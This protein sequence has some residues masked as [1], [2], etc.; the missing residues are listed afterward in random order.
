LHNLLSR[1]AEAVF[2]MARQVERANNVARILEITANFS[3]DEINTQPWQGVIDLYNDSDFFSEEYDEASPEN[4][5][6]FYIL[7]KKNPNSILNNIAYARENARALRPLLSTEIWTQLN[8]FHAKLQDVNKPQIRDEKVSD[9]CAMVK[10]S[11]QTH[12]GLVS[13]TMFRDEEWYFYTIGNALERA[14]QTTRLVDVKYHLLLPSKHGVG[15]QIDLSQWNAVL[16]SAA[17]FQAFRRVHHRGLS[18]EKVS[19]FLLFD[20]R[21]PRSLTNTTAKAYAQLKSLISL[22]AL[23]G[24]NEVLTLAKELSEQTDEGDIQGIIASGMHEWIDDVQSDIG[25]ITDALA[26]AFF[27]EG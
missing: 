13:E 7:D 5:L 22:Y 6:Q 10:Q 9:F 23:P 4:V 18:G 19:G 20:K 15:S 2:W 3:R 17:G 25:K 26:A 24:G 27:G 16:R 21:L 12:A 14:D 11:C 1:Q 8:I